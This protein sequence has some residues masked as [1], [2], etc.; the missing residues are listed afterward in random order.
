MGF[1][2]FHLDVEFA[3]RTWFG[4][5]IGSGLHTIAI[6]QRLCVL[7]LS[8]NW[9][10]IAGRAIKDVQFTSPLRSRAT[11]SADVRVEAVSPVPPSR[12]LARTVGAVRHRDDVLMTIEV[13]SFV[14]RRE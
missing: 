9:A 10:V 1:D 3:R 7:D 6:F 4:D 12:A 2:A 8:R 11:V 13:E 14:L 5:V